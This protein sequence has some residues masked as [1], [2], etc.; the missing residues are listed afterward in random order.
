ME[1]CGIG[2]IS[3]YTGKLDEPPP[4]TSKTSLQN[5]LCKTKEV[6]KIKI[7]VSEKQYPK[8]DFFL[9]KLLMGLAVESFHC[10]IYIQSL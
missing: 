7:L 5:T 3:A 2:Q 4:R 8:D 10:C 9:R 6:Q 1:S